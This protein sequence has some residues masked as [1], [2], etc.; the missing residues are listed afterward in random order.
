VFANVDLQNFTA[1][2]I[3]IYE[4]F[5]QKPWWSSNSFSYR[6]FPRAKLGLAGRIFIITT[7]RTRT[8]VSTTSGHCDKSTLRMLRQIQ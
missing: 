5:I 7:V 4:V 6:F 8:A 1:D 2:A 3:T